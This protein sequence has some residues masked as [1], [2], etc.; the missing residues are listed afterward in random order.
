MVKIQIA[1]EDKGITI[2]LNNHTIAGAMAQWG[3]IITF[4]RKSFLFKW[5]KTIVILPY[6]S[7]QA[8]KS[9]V[10]GFDSIG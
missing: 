10:H 4:D 5:S 6:T 2:G 9:L 3:V 7:F 1:K 8:K